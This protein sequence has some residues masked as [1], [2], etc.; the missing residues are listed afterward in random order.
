MKDYEAFKA[1][2]GV[3]YVA[4]QSYFDEVE[5]EFTYAD[6]LLECNGNAEL[7]VNLFDILDWQ[8]PATLL[9]EWFREGEI[10]EDCN[11]IKQTT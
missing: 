4:E 9:D 5:I 3:C 2:E 6:L 1:K 8:H 10:D 11:I 7:V